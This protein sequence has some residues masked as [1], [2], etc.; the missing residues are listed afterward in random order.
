MAT[1]LT[2]SPWKSVRH[3]RVPWGC[4]EAEVLGKA[5]VEVLPAVAVEM[6]EQCK[7]RGGALLQGVPAG[8]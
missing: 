5:F 8:G 7:L 1:E 3:G 4:T 6:L 2:P